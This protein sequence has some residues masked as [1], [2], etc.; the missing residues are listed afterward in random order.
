MGDSSI[1]AL[2]VGVYFSLTVMILS[3]VFFVTNS[4]SKLFNGKLFEATKYVASLSAETMQIHNNQIYNGSEMLQIIAD[5]KDDYFIRVATKR[6]PTGIINRDLTDLDTHDSNLY[7]NVKN[8]DS[9][10]YIDQT[11]RYVCKLL[12]NEYDCIV[13]LLFYESDYYEYVNLSQL[14][15]MKTSVQGLID[16]KK[17][18]SGTE[19]ED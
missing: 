3:V 14:E 11:S 10:Y 5:S 9:E 1:N 12:I 17:A 6:C 16:L 8:Y 18:A 15:S 7:V 13:G 19:E 2:Q 4:G